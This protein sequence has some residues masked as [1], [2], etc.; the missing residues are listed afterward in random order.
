MK[1][2]VKLFIIKIDKKFLVKV[3]NYLPAKRDVVGGVYQIEIQPAICIR[4]IYGK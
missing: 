1:N 2:F 4:P 3:L